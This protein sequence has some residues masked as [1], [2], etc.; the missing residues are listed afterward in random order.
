[1]LLAMPGGT[2]VGTVFFLLLTAAALTSMISLLE[3]PVAVVAE[4][5]RLSRPMATAIVTAMIFLAGVPSALSYGVLADIKLAGLPI[6]DAVDTLTSNVILPISGL[7]IAGFIGW[8]LTRREAIT[9]ADFSDSAL[10]SVWL[11]LIRIGVPLTIAVIFAR[12][13]GLI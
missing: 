11:W 8:R 5:T 12:T 3:V 13:L 4:R 10:A 6:L 2:V 1:V 7:A 9:A